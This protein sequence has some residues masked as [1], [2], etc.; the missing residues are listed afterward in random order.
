MKTSATSLGLFK[1]K[2]IIA[3][4]V[5]TGL[6]ASPASAATVFDVDRAAIDVILGERQD[7]APALDYYENATGA[8]SRTVGVTGSN[9][10]LTRRGLDLV[11]RYTLPTLNPGQDIIESFAFTFNITQF[12]NHSVGDPNPDR[13]QEFGLDLYLLD[14]VDPTVTGSSLFLREPNDPNHAFVGQTKL[15]P[16]PATNDGN[17]D[18]NEII[19]YTIT[20][21]DALDVLRSF[22]DGINPTQTYASFRFNLDTEYVGE[23]NERAIN[24]YI[25]N[26]DVTSSSFMMTVVPEPSSLA[27][28]GAGLGLILLRRRRH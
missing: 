24:R 21:G 19:T 18:V 20:S 1:G 2:T 16:D 4:A 7:N 15:D 25:I 10:Q 14:L 5:A 27:L 13:R 23:L 9:D 28:L 8:D 26:D 6:L 3:T 17:H 11:Y 12:R 22:Y